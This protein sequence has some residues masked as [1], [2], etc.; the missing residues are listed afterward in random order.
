MP[1]GKLKRAGGG[2]KRSIADIVAKNVEFMHEELKNLVTSVIEEDEIVDIDD[3]EELKN[4]ML[5][6]SEMIA[7]LQHFNSLMKQHIDVELL[8]VRKEREDIVTNNAAID[9][10]IRQLREQADQDD[11]AVR[12]AEEVEGKRKSGFNPEMTK[13]A[14]KKIKMATK[15]GLENF[16]PKNSKLAKEI[17][18]SVIGGDDDDVVLQKR[19]LGESDTK[20][21]YSGV[22]FKDPYANKGKKGCDHHLDKVSIDVLQSKAPNKPFQCPMMGCNGV[23]EAKTS[24][25]DDKFMRKI[26][27]FLQ[28]QEAGGAKA[29][30]KKKAM[31]VEDEEDYTE[32]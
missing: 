25:A 16:E 12:L 7:Q 21:P 18:K 22:L 14:V 1:V 32:I 24:E 30:G 3:N 2:G 17:R 6:S 29:Q 31:V 15:E 20:C 23:W 19:G 11:E 26:Q 5:G 10:E 27:K 4:R 28:N 8:K 13:E 9:E